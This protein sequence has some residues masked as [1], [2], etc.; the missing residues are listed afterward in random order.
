MRQAGVRGWGA[1][2]QPRM[3]VRPDHQ[4][5]AMKTQRPTR[6]SPKAITAMASAM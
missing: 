5:Q 6:I 4:A 3:L 1:L 2:S